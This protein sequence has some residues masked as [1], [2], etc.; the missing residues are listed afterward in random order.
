MDGARAGLQGT[1]GGVIAR[2]DGRGGGRG[3]R[4]SGG[5][6]KPQPRAKEP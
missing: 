3:L 5:A 2:D 4:S 6:V 1:A